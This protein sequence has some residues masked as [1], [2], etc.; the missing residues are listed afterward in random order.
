MRGQN[1]VTAILLVGMA[2]VFI[3]AIYLAH[4][5]ACKKNKKTRASNSEA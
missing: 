4:H 3:S 1:W 5:W 2:L